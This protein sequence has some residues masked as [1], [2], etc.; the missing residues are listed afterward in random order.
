MNVNVDIFFFFLVIIIVL[1]GKVFVGYLMVVKDE[2]IGVDFGFFSIIS[3]GKVMCG[4]TVRIF[5]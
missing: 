2:R 1:N 5:L 3:G 4:I